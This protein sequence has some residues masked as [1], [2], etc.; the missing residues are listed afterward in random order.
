MQ[1]HDLNMINLNELMIKKKQNEMIM[2]FQNKLVQQKLEK[3]LTMYHI[4]NHFQQQI[5]S[6]QQPHHYQIMKNYYFDVNVMLHVMH[7][8]LV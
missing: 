6:L 8:L 2:N 5:G 3:N 4:K 7:C 1:N